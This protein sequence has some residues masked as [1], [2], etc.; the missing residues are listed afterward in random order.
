MLFQ[1]ENLASEDWCQYLQVK[2]VLP[3]NVKTYWRKTEHFLLPLLL[4]GPVRKLQHVINARVQKN[5]F[6]G[7]YLQLVYILIFT[8][9]LKLI[10][11][12]LTYM[13]A[14]ANVNKEF[15]PKIAIKKTPF[16]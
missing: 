12:N 13:K 16:E 10:C 9:L 8:T 14:G 2:Y 15:G 4:L 1:V 6:L 5:A 7:L 11:E 3:E